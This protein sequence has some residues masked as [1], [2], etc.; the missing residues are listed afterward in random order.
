[1]PSSEL[2]IFDA[3]PSYLGG[4]RQLAR[5]LYRHIAETGY[6]PAR[7]HVL[8]DAFMGGGSMSLL[9]KALGYR[10]IANDISVR[11][12]TIGEA[13]IVND[14]ET[15]TAEDL[16]IAL[17][18]DPGARHRP[19]PKLLPFTD[20]AREVLIRLVAAAEE[21][22]SPAKRALLRTLAVKLTVRVAMWGQ[23]TSQGNSRIRNGL[24][25]DMTLGQMTWLKVAS[26]PQK[27]LLNEAKL[28]NAGV[29]ANGER[30]EVHCADVIEFLA[31][32]Q[33]D[34]AYLDPPY[35]GTIYYEREYAGIDELLTG[36]PVHVERSRFSRNEGWKFIRDVAEAAEH[37]PVLVLS[38]GNE[39]VEL[40]ELE[41][42]LREV[43]RDVTAQAVEYHHLR[44]KA[45]DEK[46]ERN[47]EFILVA[48][49]K[50]AVAA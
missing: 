19:S 3:L 42:L 23:I 43:G 22:A 27:Q 16:A 41:E 50:V 21:V 15:L 26:R 47:R 28:L 34:I 11:S 25:D 31:G 29:F 7:G 14:R 32:V 18:A 2:A 13:L 49:S 33:G 4:K 8:I 46:K 10:V 12:Q 24:Y 40:G 44:S 37:I 35:P 45:T 30:N 6:P 48:R 38:L 1:M 20:H 17:Q 9:G 36:Q 39:T 5:V